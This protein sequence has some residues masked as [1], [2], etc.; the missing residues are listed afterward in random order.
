MGVKVKHRDEGTC[1]RSSTID[2]REGS[3][4]D[5][6]TSIPHAENKLAQKIG[7]PLQASLKFYVNV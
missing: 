6:Q 2:S 7:L 3:N 4:P 1:R 5:L